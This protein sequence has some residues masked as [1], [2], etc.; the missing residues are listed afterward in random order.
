MMGSIQVHHNKLWFAGVN[1]NWKLA[2]FEIHEIQETLEQITKFQQE[3]EESRMTGSLLPRLDSIQLAVSEG[4]VDRFR[5]QY[6]LLT[7]ACND[8]HRATD[9]GFNVVKIPDEPPFTN[10]EFK[11]KDG[12]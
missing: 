4:K 8:C 6:A 10:Q 1:A 2:A 12:Q 9:F 7:D 5:E 3:R 11:L